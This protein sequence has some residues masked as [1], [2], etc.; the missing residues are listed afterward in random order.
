MVPLAP[1][2][3]SRDRPQR[4]PQRPERSMACHHWG[5]VSGLHL[6][7]PQG[8]AKRRGHCT[9]APYTFALTPLGTHLP[10][11]CHCQM[12]WAAPRDGHLS[13]LKTLQL[14]AAGA[15]PPV[16]DRQNRVLLVWSACGGGKPPQL[17][18]TPEAVMARSH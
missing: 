13:L 3:G 11:S 8:L 9:Q 18:L 15:A 16:G 5:H 2:T 10:C 7:S 17:S 12:L 6:Q 14:G 4:L 1:S